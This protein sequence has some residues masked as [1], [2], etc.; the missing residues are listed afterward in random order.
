V[1]CVIAPAVLLC[2]AASVLLGA[3]PAASLVLVVL[4]VAA[5]VVGYGRLV[6]GHWRFGQVGRMEADMRADA[7]MR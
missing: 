4:Q 3:S 7:E 2:V 1:A 6:R 5:Y